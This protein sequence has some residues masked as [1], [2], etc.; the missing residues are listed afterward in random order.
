[1]PMGPTFVSADQAAGLIEDGVTVATDGFTLLGVAEEIF[2]ALERRYL[3]TG[4]PRDLTVVAAAGQSANALGFEHLA[5]D[6]LVSRVIGSHWGLQPEMSRFLGQDKAQAICLPLGQVCALYRAIAA[7]RPGHLTTIGVGTFVDPALDGGRINDSARLAPDYVQAIEIDGQRCLLYRS[8]PIQVGILRATVVD[9]D[10]NCAM[11]EE[12]VRLDALS[13]AQAVRAS[14][15]LVLVQAKRRV[16][17]GA[18]AP[19]DVTVPATFVDHIVMTSDASRFHRQSAGFVFDRRLIQADPDH[20]QFDGTWPPEDRLTVGLRAVRD[21]APGDIINIGTGLPGDVVGAALARVGLAGQVTVTVEA[22]IHGGLPLGGM[23]F[24]AALYPHA[25]I[26]QGH[27]LD[28]YDGGGLD[29]TF[30]GVGEVDRDGNVNVSRLGGRVIGCGGFIDITQ[31][32]R[33]IYFCFVMGGRHQKF[34]PQ[35]SHLTFNAPV[36]RQAGQE[37]WYITERAVFRLTDDGLELTELA[38]GYDIDRDVLQ[39]IPFPVRVAPQVSPMLRLSPAHTGGG[40]SPAGPGDHPS[41]A[42]KES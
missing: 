39:T 12:A 41:A 5:H 4:T 2:D 20:D 10:G 18:I 32:T 29:A 6:G 11:A 13:I 38:D 17:R 3:A 16:P 15:G 28:F 26:A 31:S 9:D 19:G 35:V 1:M 40:T 27:Q 22:G 36:A 21:V 33:R 14:G 42:R 24:G 34:V 8:F 30:M 37:V 23:D 25:I 7:G